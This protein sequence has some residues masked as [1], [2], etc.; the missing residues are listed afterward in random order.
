[1]ARGGFEESPVLEAGSV[2][3]NEGASVEGMTPEVLVIPLLVFAGRLT[4][5]SIGTVRMIFT[6]NGMRWIPAALGFFEVVIWVLAI[7]GAVNNLD[8]P[9]VLIGYAGGF[10]MGTLVGAMIEARLAIG[11]RIVTVVN[12]EPLLNLAAHIREGGFAVTRVAGDGRAG[13]VEVVIAVV[14]RRAL[15][16]LSE[17]IRAVAPSAFMTVERAER[18]VA[19]FLGPGA[20]TAQRPWFRGLSVRK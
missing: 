11:Y 19:G 4:D 1:M 2:E 7:G 14:K 10:A 12:P 16:R 18:A 6:I 3:V 15:P 5:V 9:L 8:Q 17:H 13:P 20:R